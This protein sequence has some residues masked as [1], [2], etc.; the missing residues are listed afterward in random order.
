MKSLCRMRLDAVQATENSQIVVLWCFHAESCWRWIYVSPPHP[1]SSSF[2]HC[3]CHI[4]WI[5][6]CFGVW[7][8]LFS[9]GALQCRLK[10]SLSRRDWFVR[11]QARK[12]KQEKKHVGWGLGGITS[13][14][15]A[16]ALKKILSQRQLSL[17]RFTNWSQ[18]K[19]WFNAAAAN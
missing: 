1:P 10:R 8:L 2:P 6:M 13:G 17:A 18:S 9:E 7:S 11:R 5:L 19:L 15:G 4:K 14:G 16:S 3:L 12:E